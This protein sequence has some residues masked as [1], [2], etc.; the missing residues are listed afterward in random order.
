MMTDK[1]REEADESKLKRLKALKKMYFG[2]T[3]ADRKMASLEVR[4]KAKAR[5]SMASERSTEM[6]APQEPGTPG[7]EKST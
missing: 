5:Q 7:G 6:G 2:K 3:K 1:D 4:G